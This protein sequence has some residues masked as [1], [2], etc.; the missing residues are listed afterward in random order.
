MSCQEP[1]NM[2]PLDPLPP[3]PQ[4]SASSRTICSEGSRSVS[5]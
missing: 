5:S 2:P 3:L 4:M 1:E